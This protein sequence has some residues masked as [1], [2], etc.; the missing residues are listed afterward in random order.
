MP[1]VARLSA[2]LRTTSDV[3]L[4]VSQQDTNEDRI[5]PGFNAHLR[6]AQLNVN[7]TRIQ[8][9]EQPIGVEGNGLREIFAS[10]LSAVTCTGN[11]W[12][13]LL[14]LSGPA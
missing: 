2:C 7:H 14:V 9:G 3:K 6:L 11:S 1:L 5:D 12:T 8:V 10:L 4:A 13:T